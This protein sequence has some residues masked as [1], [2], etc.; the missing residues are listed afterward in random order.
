MD[1]LNEVN[2]SAATGKQ[3]EQAGTVLSQ[4]QLKLEL[5]LTL[6]KIWCIKL[7]ILAELC[8]LGGVTL[9]FIP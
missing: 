4:A 8:Y 7:I 6:F 2:I 1:E 9:L 3:D 5:E